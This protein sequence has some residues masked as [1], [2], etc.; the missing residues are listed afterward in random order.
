LIHT[1]RQR[2]ATAT[3]LLLMLATG[4][5]LGGVGC[6]RK[7]SEAF[8]QGQAHLQKK[9][10]AKAI[11]S[12]EKAVRQN[13]GFGEAY[14]NLGAA[15]FQLAVVKL[16]ELVQKHGSADLKA[17]LKATGGQTARAVSLAPEREVALAALRKELGQLPAAQADP[18][19]ALLHQAIEAKLRARALFQQGKFVVI[20]KSSTR[21]SMLGKLDRLARLRALLRKRGEQDR[22]LWLLAVARPALL[23]DRPVTKPR[24]RPKGVMKP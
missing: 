5:A 11:P 15:R 14:Y 3:V 18:I 13:S 22:G 7:G 9:R 1:T 8:N 21:R 6:R 23:T 4:L 19:V 2:E 12:F 10:Y 16:N 24:L 20:R 17:A